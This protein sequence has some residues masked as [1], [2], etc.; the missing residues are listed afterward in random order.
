MLPDCELYIKTGET[1]GVCP[2]ETYQR[3]WYAVPSADCTIHSY[4]FVKHSV[5]GSRVELIAEDC[6]AGQSLAKLALKSKTKKTMILSIFHK[7]DSLSHI[8]VV[9]GVVSFNSTSE[10]V[11]C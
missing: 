9:R 2:A 3:D 1:E 10:D 6:P 11:R 5:F 4:V 8:C 7:A